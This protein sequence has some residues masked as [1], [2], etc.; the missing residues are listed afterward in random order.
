[1]A[2]KWIFFLPSSNTFSFK[3][4]ILEELIT[5]SSNY[6]I[7]PCRKHGQPDTVRE[8]LIPLL[9]LNLQVHALRMRVIPHK[10]R[11]LNFLVKLHLA[12]IKNR[13][14]GETYLIQLLLLWVFSI[15]ISSFVKL[16]CKA[17]SSV[18]WKKM[19]KKQQEKNQRP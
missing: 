17:N 12:L 9:F 3:T 7:N 6:T 14:S 16:P 4:T 1:M 8:P 15:L 18:R 11:N 5:K 19:K 13:I 2:A 10:I